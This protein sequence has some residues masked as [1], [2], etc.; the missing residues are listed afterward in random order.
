MIALTCS[1]YLIRFSD[2]GSLP[3]HAVRLG[4][5]SVQLGGLGDVHGG[6]HED[7]EDVFDYG[8]EGC[9]G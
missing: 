6:G 1:A 2:N 9:H 3:D 7:G 4:R 8:E 5:A